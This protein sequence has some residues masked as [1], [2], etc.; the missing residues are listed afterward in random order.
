[1]GASTVSRVEIDRS[2]R[3]IQDSRVRLASARQALQ[4][5]REALARQHYRQMVCA[6]C[7]QTMRGQRSAA[8]VGG[9]SRQSICFDC[10]AQVFWELDRRPTLPPLATHAPAGDHPSHTLPLREEARRAGGTDTIADLA[11]YRGLLGHPANTPLT[12]RTGN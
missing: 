2:R 10:F 12:P 3:L 11:R 6:W 9:Q 1:M 4:Q 7:Q 8:T 5:A